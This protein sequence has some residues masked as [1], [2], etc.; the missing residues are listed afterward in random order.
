MLARVRR[1]LPAVIGL[2]LFLVAL[3]VLRTELRTVTWHELAQDVLTMPPGQLGL[4][5][6]LTV[7]SYAALTGYDFLALAS[8]GKRLPREHVV[9]TSFLAYAIANNV[10]WAMLSGASV[11]YRFYT[12]WKVTATILD[13]SSFPIR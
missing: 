2:V 3:E 13:G 12:R 8:I 4:A 11:R 9:L 6:V 10:G 7:L 5:L 1:A